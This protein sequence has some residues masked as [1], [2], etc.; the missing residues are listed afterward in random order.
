MNLVLIY[1]PPGVGKLTVAKELATLT[2][3]KLFDNHASIDVI[4]RVFGFGEGPFWDLVDNLRFAV[5]AAAAEHDVSLI[6]TFVYA[7]PTDMPYID[8]V[9]NLIEPY[10][11]RLCLAQLIC[12]ER[13]LDARLQSDQRRSIGK[14]TSLETAIEMRRS[15]E[16]FEAIPDRKNLSIDNTHL[17]PDEVARRICDHYGLPTAESGSP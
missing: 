17:Q 15:H 8:R 2:G 4:R 5:F 16:L 3:Y 14:L 10:G 7:H 1:G 12:D 11:G 9:A 13:L 6:F